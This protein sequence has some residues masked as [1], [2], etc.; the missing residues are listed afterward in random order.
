MSFTNKW[1]SGLPR[2]PKV[3]ISPIISCFNSSIQHII[4]SFFYWFSYL[5]SVGNGVI[6][7]KFKSSNSSLPLVRE[8]DKC[9][10]ASWIWFKDNKAF[11]KSL[12][13]NKQR[14]K[15]DKRVKMKNLDL[16]NQH[17][18]KSKL[19]NGLNGYH[20]SSYSCFSGTAYV[21]DSLRTLNN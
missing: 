7:S 20:P 10:G 13:S 18:N 2:F 8:K 3:N 14:I 1:K 9:S 21:I 4:I 12:L 5:N 16:K 6:C 11:W 19:E 15:R 17:L